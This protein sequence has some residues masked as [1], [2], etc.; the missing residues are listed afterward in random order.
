MITRR[1]F[2]LGTAALLLARPAF[3]A[4]WADE[5]RS[6]LEAMAAELTELVKPWRGPALIARP[7]R[8]SVV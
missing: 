5:L 8:K 3:A 1:Q 2:G 6:R 7:D 4:D